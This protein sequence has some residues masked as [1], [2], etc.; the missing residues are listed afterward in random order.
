VVI[1]DEPTLGIDPEGVQQLLG[2]IHELSAKDHRTV[3]ISSHQLYQIQQI[4]DRVGIFVKGKLIA[5]GSI[6]ELNR[7][8][9]DDKSVVVEFSAKPDD[10]ALEKLILGVPD[11]IEVHKELGSYIVRASS[12]VRNALADTAIRKGYALQQVGRHGADL[13]DVYRQYFEKE[14]TA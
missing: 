1:L 5:C 13:Y 11:V 4:C 9:A 12:D 2:L 14:G 7:A 10:E 8:L 3:L 6:E